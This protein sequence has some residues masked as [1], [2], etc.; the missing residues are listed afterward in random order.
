MKDPQASLAQIEQQRAR[1]QAKAQRI[2]AKMKVVERKAAI[3]RKIILGDLIIAEARRLPQIAV[4]LKEKIAD[5]DE[6][7][8]A[9]FD[10]WS[11]DNEPNSD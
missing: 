7:D 2:K 10:G 8:A 3:R 6:R 4:L 9:V 11:I 1:L 5:L